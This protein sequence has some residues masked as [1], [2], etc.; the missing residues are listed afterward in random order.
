VIGF[1]AAGPGG[2]LVGAALGFVLGGAAAPKDEPGPGPGPGPGPD[3]TPPVDPGEA[4]T[5]LGFRARKIET[6]FPGIFAKR[7]SG[8]EKTWKEIPSANP[9]IK[10]L[11]QD[12][13]R[14]KALPGETGPEKPWNAGDLPSTVTEA[15]VE[16]RTVPWGLEPWTLGAVIGIPNDWKG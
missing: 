8:S 15:E 14:V 9:T 16:R 11:Y 13:W 6:P 12:Q 10:I 4:K 7:Y 5:P 2:A 1:L 3:P